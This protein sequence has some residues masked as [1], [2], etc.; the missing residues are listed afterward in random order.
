MGLTR[1]M[2]KYEDDLRD[3]WQS[4]THRASWQRL[5]RAALAAHERVRQR[6]VFVSGEIHLA[7]RAEMQSRTGPLHQLVASGIAHD[8][9]PRLWARALGWLAGLGESPLAGHPIRTKPLP[10]QRSRYIAERNLL[11]LACR[12]GA[13]QAVWM[14]EDSGLTPP[15]ALD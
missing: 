14:L 9:P 5:L 6:V 3:Q 4:R 10:G 7:T 1:R 2:K 15:L 11:T 8:P 13:W 12:D